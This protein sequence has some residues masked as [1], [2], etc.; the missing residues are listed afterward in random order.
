M[1]IAAVGIALLTAYYLGLRVG[2]VAG[3]VSALL[4]LA[5]MIVPGWAAAAYAIVVAWVIG[6]CL[7]GPRVQK[8]T[9]KDRFFS[10]SRGLARKA[11][12]FWRSK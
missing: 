1:L 10:M 3:G 9:T 7:I 4:L 8:E 2:L 6:V 12:G 5:A 11:L